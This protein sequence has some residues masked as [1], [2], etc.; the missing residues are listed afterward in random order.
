MS[1][2]KRDC[3]NVRAGRHSNLLMNTRVGA[4]RN[5]TYTFRMTGTGDTPTTENVQQSN[6]PGA[7]TYARVPWLVVFTWGPGSE[8][9]AT[10]LSAQCAERGVDIVDVRAVD[11]L[12]T[13]E[14]VERYAV[15]V[16]VVPAQS[17]TS[18]DA[19][20]KQLVDGVIGRYR[21]RRHDNLSAVIAGRQRYAFAGVIHVVVLTDGTTAEPGTA[22]TAL[23]EKACVPHWMQ[24]GDATLPDLFE[25]FDGKVESPRDAAPTPR[26]I[27]HL[28]TLW[29]EAREWGVATP[30]DVHGIRLAHPARRFLL[31]IPFLRAP[32]AW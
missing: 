15:V 32:A 21:G 14:D 8:E 24:V 16:F 18:R 19:R 23:L 6:Y 12:T 5:D 22:L 26:P 1:G 11:E 10:Q 20:S 3:V 7:E 28:T 17:V 9:V 27:D 13:P 29:A 4:P 25:A 30:E 31:S 2:V